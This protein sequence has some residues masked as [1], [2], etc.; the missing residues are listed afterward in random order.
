MSAQ[1]YFNKIQ[2]L[3]A[4]AASTQLAHVEQAAALVSDAIRQDGIL[5]TFGT[6]HSHLIAED[7]VYRAGG[8]AAV[9]VI[10]EP[11]LVEGA[12]KSEK[13]ER[14]EGFGKAIYHA[15]PFTPPDVLLV[16]S[17]SGRN[18]A[19]VELALEAK[20][21]GVPVIAIT[22]LA[23]SQAISSR[24]SSGKKLYEVADVVLDNGAP[25]GD[26][27]IAM[28]GLPVP[29][30]AVSSVTGM[31]L[32]Q[33]VIVQTVRNLLDAGFEPPVFRSGNLDGSDTFNA[34]VRAHYALRIRAW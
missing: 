19:P 5:H 10:L 33:A 22:S 18:A 12:A 25:L 24:H 11:S 21:H 32:I 26:A 2:E 7:V 1:A 23:Y 15:H 27:C 17:N 9:D 30:G 3:L 29:T 20:A 13:I 6:G 31:L 14:L 16:V 28:D 8:L 34:A 4:W